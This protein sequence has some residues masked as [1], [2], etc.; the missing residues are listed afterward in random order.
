V[1]VLVELS[2]F[3]R[4]QDE[5]AFRHAVEAGARQARTGRL[6]PHKAAVQILES[7]GEPAKPRR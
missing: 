4:M 5:L 3:E 2:E 6:R 1:A 7:F